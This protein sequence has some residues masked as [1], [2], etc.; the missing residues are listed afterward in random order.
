LII[1]AA[2]L[3][4]AAVTMAKGIREMVTESKDQAQKPDAA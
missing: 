1:G 2:I 3:A 4:P